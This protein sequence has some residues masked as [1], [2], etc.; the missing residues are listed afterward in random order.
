MVKGLIINKFRG[1][2]TI[3]DPGVKM[4]EEKAKGRTTS[5]LKSLM[6]LSPETAVILVD[7]KEKT[8]PVESLKKDD[9]FVVRPGDKIPVDGIVEKGQSAV[10]ES[11]LTGESIP[12]EK[13]VGDAVT[14]ATINTSGFMVCRATR[15]GEDTTLS[16]IIRMVSDAAATKAPIAKIADKVSGIFVP[17]VIAIAVGL[18]FLTNYLNNKKATSN[19]NIDYDTCIVGNMFNRPYNEY[20]VFLYSS[21]DK[22]A[23]TYKGLITSYKDKDDALKVYYVDMNDKFNSAY[24]SETSNKKPTESSEVKINES[25]LIL[26]K[27]GKVEKYYES[28]EDYKN[29]LK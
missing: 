17:V 22:N 11:A 21:T 6:N 27:D 20:Y 7:G 8:V 14:S 24:L 13:A 23:S 25:A 10:N 29:A 19:I 16:Q 3:L 2:K 9:L 26:I 4:L 5:A 15:V 1:D 28:L 12:V 18:F